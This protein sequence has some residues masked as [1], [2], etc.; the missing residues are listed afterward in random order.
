MEK[1]PGLV[2][3]SELRGLMVSFRNALEA[4]EDVVSPYK[5]YNTVT[6]T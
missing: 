4:A 6:E 1:D 3:Q 5:G 2:E